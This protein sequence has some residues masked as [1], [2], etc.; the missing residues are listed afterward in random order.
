MAYN[1]NQNP[2]LGE[3]TI[4]MFKDIY[5]YGKRMG[6]ADYWWGMLGIAILT[7]IDILVYSLIPETWLGGLFM[8]RYSIS[9]ISC[10][11]ICDSKKT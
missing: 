2:N 7:F 1:E 8:F 4:L 5:R 10:L 11:S 3:S 6:R 9:I